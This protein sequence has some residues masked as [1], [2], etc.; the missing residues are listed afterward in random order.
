MYEENVHVTKII[1]LRFFFSYIQLPHPPIKA[2]S[3]TV[4]TLFSLPLE[5]LWNKVSAQRVRTLNASCTVMFTA[6]SGRERVLRE[7]T[8]SLS[9]G[10]N[11]R[12]N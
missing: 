10:E 6:F 7:L 1:R 2:D 3:F 5:A 4:N 11:G 9:R 12:V 8:H